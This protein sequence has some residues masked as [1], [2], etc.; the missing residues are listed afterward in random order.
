MKHPYALGRILDH[1][2]YVSPDA[3]LRQLRRTTFVSVDKRYFYFAVPKAACTQMKELLRTIEHAPPIK[4]FADGSPQ[5]RR[6]M[7][8][9]ARPN[10]PLPS[11]VDLDDRT[12]R[13]VLESVDFLRMT[14]V[15]NPYTR[16]VSAW[17]NKVLLCEPGVEEAY[18]DIKG[19]LPDFH[20]KSMI[21]FP[22]FVDYITDKCDLRLCNNH[23]RRQVNHT[24][25]AAMNFSLVVKIEQLV[26]GLRQFE[27]H[28][29]LSNSLT[30]NGRNR[31]VST[32]PGV[33]TKELA[34][35]VY[36]LYHED[37]KALGYD[38][39]TWQA[40]TTN[41]SQQSCVSEDRFRDEIIERNLIISSLYEERDRLQAQLQW[42]SSLRVGPAINGLVALQSMSRRGT[43][44]IK[45]GIRR[46]L[47]STGT[48]T[49]QRNFE[50][51]VTKN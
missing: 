22:E 21:S 5:T 8:I 35:K 37:F 16:L 38:R 19:R 36:A 32:Q 40:G 51:K 12:Q 31:S 14:V 48:N 13:E 42:I 44:K 17:S 10:V 43:Q 28:L 41:A 45:G 11:L 4:V 25:F 23:W 6:D 33:Y 50:D 2:P 9:H 18:L 34:D 24:F 47:R 46:L 39:N 29:G 15:R 49:M 30:A 27:K 3:V 1:C 20:E 7:F 26:D